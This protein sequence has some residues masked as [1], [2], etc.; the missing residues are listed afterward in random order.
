MGIDTPIVPA[1]ETHVG[2]LWRCVV[3]PRDIFGPGDTGRYRMI[4]RQLKRGWF[5]MFGDGQVL[6][7][8]LYIDNFLEL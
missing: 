6:Y 3:T 8:P 2:D 1:S 4:F 5:P 7:H